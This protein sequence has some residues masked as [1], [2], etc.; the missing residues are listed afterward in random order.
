MCRI[1]RLHRRRGRQSGA[2][3]VFQIRHPL[4]GLWI[5]QIGRCARRTSH[6]NFEKRRLQP[7]LRRMELG[8]PRPTDCEWSPLTDT[9]IGVSLNFSPSAPDSIRAKP[10]AI[11]AQQLELAS[12]VA[13]EIVTSPPGITSVTRFRRIKNAL[14]ATIMAKFQRYKIPAATRALVR[15]TAAAL[16]VASIFFGNAIGTSPTSNCRRAGRGAGDRPAAHSFYR[17]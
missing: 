15:M 17:R 10:K 9:E 14:G 5:D 16:A 12:P 4:A 2:R 13:G 7:H 1:R 11:V 3:Q 6:R 8:S